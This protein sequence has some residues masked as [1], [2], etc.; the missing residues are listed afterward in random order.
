MTETA[1]RVKRMKLF[2]SIYKDDKIKFKDTASSFDQKHSIYMQM[3]ESG[4]KSA[5]ERHENTLKLR[6]MLR[7]RKS[8]RLPQGKSI[9]NQTLPSGNFTQKRSVSY[10]NGEGEQIEEITRSNSQ[11]NYP[12]KREKTNFFN[13]TTLGFAQTP[14]NRSK[15]TR[16]YVKNPHPYIEESCLKRSESEKKRPLSFRI[17]RNGVKKNPLPLEF[18]EKLE[19]LN[20]KTKNFNSLPNSKIIDFIIENRKSVKSD[21]KLFNGLKKLRN[22]N[23]LKD[24]SLFTR[25]IKID[26]FKGYVYNDEHNSNTN[27]G[28]SRNKGGMFFYR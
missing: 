2:K 24:K 13:K 23:L 11:D 22:N 19:K 12:L 3:Y 16:N 27:N 25:K 26:S 8:R 21:R 10:D 14:K 4:L 17:K 6:R 7:S 9:M 15:S 5:I 28:Y 20:F 18:R 1:R